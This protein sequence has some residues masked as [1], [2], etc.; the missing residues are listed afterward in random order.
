[1][2][3]PS[4]LLQAISA[5]GGGKIALVVGA[6]CSVEEPTCIPVAREWS[7]EVHRRL[8]DDGVLQNGDCSDPD[9]LSLVADAVFEKRGSQRDLV[10][11]LRDQYDLKLA[12]PNDGY[13]VAAAL[14]CEGTISSVVTLNFDL[15][16]SN[17]LSELGAGEIVGVIECPQD[18]PRQKA[19]NIYY[20][21]R[22]VNATDP[23]LWVLRSA[24]LQRDWRGHWEPIITTRVLTAPVVVF[25]GLGSPIGV[26]IESAKL[27]RSAL[28]TV[29]TLY[30]VDPADKANSMFFKELA[31]DDSAYIQC[32]WCQFMDNLSQRLL[33]EQI[34]QLKR[35]VDQKIRD[36]RLPHED[37]ADLLD[38]LQA[39]GLV[40]FGILRANWLLHNK[41][42][43]PVD[44]NALSLIADLL[45]V[46]AMVGRVSGAEA[47]I[48][49][50]GLVE[51]H[52]DG[53]P[54]IAY[55]IASGRG[56]RGR[57]A[58]EAALE[59]RRRQ[60]RSRLVRPCGAIVGGT[61]GS[62]T[63]TVTPPTDVIRGDV[64][65]DIVA[66]SAVLPLL[67]IDEL[68]ANP[69]RVRQVVP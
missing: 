18:L 7:R 1:M 53:R 8:I 55:I 51:F 60:Y 43:C 30:H 37:V 21:H 46:L 5:P 9:D 52:R 31:L 54:V 29:R 20:L 2:A 16:L 32:G 69:D 66:G 17:A 22:N 44:L 23:E 50:D 19:F 56:H 33:I 13:R 4:E 39:L 68:R 49:E 34:V 67:H 64:S 14:L 28:P 24:S 41:R 47:V 10:E 3:L 26:L 25:A 35:A 36:D 48:A 63:T 15:A 12:S 62:W 61:S 59:P 65:E 57:L 40:E 58:L 11:R 42:Y 38:R 27:L 45:L 6:G